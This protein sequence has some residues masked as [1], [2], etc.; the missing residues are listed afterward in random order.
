M[1]ETADQYAKRM[2]DR[3]REDLRSILKTPY[4]KRFVWKWLS[5]CGVFRQSFV[6]GE[7]DSTAFAEGRRSIGN[8][9]LMEV[10]DVRPES[11]V[12]M[13]KAAKEDEDGRKAVAANESDEA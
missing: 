4:G 7:S 10:F 2:F 13:T 9:L 8:A 3:E 12:E 11:Y 5:R 1:S 6:Q